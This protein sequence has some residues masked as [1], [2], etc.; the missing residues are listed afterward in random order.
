[1]YAIVQR[2]AQN[3]DWVTKPQSGLA[4]AKIY[5]FKLFA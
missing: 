2:E 3:L 4:Y 1:M 5:D